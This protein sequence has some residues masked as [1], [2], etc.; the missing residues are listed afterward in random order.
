[1]KNTNHI[2]GIVAGK[3]EA[4]SVTKG[5]SEAECEASCTANGCTYFAY[6]AEACLEYNIPYSATEFTCGI[7]TSGLAIYLSTGKCSNLSSSSTSAASSST[8]ST[9]TSSV[10]PTTS[11]CYQNAGVG[12]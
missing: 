1:V 11:A 3:A 5:G 7:Q 10:S 8:S 6:N 2:L 4:S 9:I 12:C